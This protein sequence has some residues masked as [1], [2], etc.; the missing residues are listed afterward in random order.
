MKLQG[1]RKIGAML[2][3]FT[4]VALAGAV[5][6]QAGA[7]ASG[8][9]GVWVVQVTPRN[10]TTGAASG[11]P[12]AALLTFHEGRTI[13]ESVANLGFQPNQR[14]DGHGVW[15]RLGRSDYSQDVVA[16][17]RFDSVA[18]LPGQP[19]F[20]PSLPVS[21][22][23]RTGSVTLRQTVT[24]RGDNDFDSTG[25]VEFFD[26]AGVSYRTGCSTQVGRRFE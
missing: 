11:A 9:A 17:I 2:A 21:P 8:I 13:S 25:T 24:L 14:T 6:S 5:P 22:G 1:M 3:L 12:I 23:Y 16:L 7:P 15:R 19:G 4:G 18:N 10:C 20:D 26:A